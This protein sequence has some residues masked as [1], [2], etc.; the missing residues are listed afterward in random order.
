M[1]HS[2]LELPPTFIPHSID[3]SSHVPPDT[4]ELPYVHAAI[5]W[6]PSGQGRSY[7]VC[8]MSAGSKAE[9]EAMEHINSE[10]GRSI[11]YYYLFDQF[12]HGT[13]IG[14]KTYPS[15]KKFVSL[16][17]SAR[18]K[19]KHAIELLGLLYLMSSCIP[20]PK[21]MGIKLL[22]HSAK[23]GFLYSQYF[24]AS[25]YFS[26]EKSLFSSEKTALKYLL[27]AASAGLKEAKELL[28]QMLNHKTGAIPETCFVITYYSAL[29]SEGG[30]RKARLLLGKALFF[31]NRG[32]LQNRE[33]G[34]PIISEL[35]ADG[36]IPANDAMTEIFLIHNSLTAR[37]AEE[38]LRGA[39][40]K[41]ERGASFTLAE[42]LNQGNREKE[43][44]EVQALKESARY[45][46]DKRAIYQYRAKLLRTG[47][48]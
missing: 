37:E 35:A 34:L 47:F 40:E 17:H 3:I 45:K 28:V 5:T 36:Y 14:T 20:D 12:H 16:A 38:L 11:T 13:C 25:L 27:G 9:K 24:L 48:R 29:L 23:K 41:R 4:S 18:K 7:Q 2:A 46:G 43:S 44:L 30:E 31:G 19:C 33:K 6:W 39:I 21:T 8:H 10:S 22:K 32:V 26:G 42:L 15:V 1:S